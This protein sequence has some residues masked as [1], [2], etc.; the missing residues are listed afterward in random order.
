MPMTKRGFVSLRVTSPIDRNGMRSVSPIDSITA[1][2]RND[3]A[4]TSPSLRPA[5]RAVHSVRGMRV[6]SPLG[7]ACVRITQTR[8]SRCTPFEE[9]NTSLTRTFFAPAKSDA[10][11]PRVTV[12]VGE[13]AANNV[14]ISTGTSNLTPGI[15]I[16]HLDSDCDTLPTCHA[17]TAELSQDCHFILPKLNAVG[18]TMLSKLFHS[19]CIRCRLYSTWT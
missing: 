13:H 9:Y 17:F 14:P 12:R 4:S 5:A 10:V 15:F 7:E 2:G 3:S 11:T 1:S 18:Y 6:P 8:V 19:S 16:T